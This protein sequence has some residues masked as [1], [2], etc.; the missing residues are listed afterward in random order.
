M[1]F[2]NITGVLRILKIWEFSEISGVF[3]NFKK[4]LGISEMFKIYQVF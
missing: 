4:F 1:N 3:R 2:E